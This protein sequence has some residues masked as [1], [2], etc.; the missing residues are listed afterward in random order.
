MILELG[1]GTKLE[2]DDKK[3]LDKLIRQHETKAK[4]EKAERDRLHGIAM[5]EA[6]KHACDIMQRFIDD[7]DCPRGWSLNPPE[8]RFLKPKEHRNT[9]LRVYHTGIYETNWGRAEAEHYGYQIQWILENGSGFDTA[10]CLKANS[11]PFDLQLLAIGIYEHVAAFYS[12]PIKL[13]P[14]LEAR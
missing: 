13:I 4:K 2:A 3:S 8:K 10:V 1:D 5:G 6:Y 11:E 14:W 7:K 12:L 9:F